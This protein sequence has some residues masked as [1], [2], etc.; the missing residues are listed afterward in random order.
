MPLHLFD[1]CRGRVRFRSF[2][3]SAPLQHFGSDGDGPISR[4]EAL[5]VGRLKVLASSPQALAVVRKLR[6]PVHLR[7]RQSTRSSFT[8]FKESK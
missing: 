2:S 3:R 7:W 4:L 5:A 6:H 1:V 8:S